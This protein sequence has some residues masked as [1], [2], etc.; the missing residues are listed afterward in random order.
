LVAGL[1][2]SRSV[3][4]SF[5]IYFLCA[6]AGYLW[7]EVAR[8]RS[9]LAAL[10]ASPAGPRSHQVIIT[11]RREFAT[12]G[13]TSYV[14]GI[15]RASRQVLLPLWGAHIG[16]DVTQISLVYGVSSIIDVSL[17]YPSGSL[18][19]RYGRRAV[20]IPCMGFLAVGHLLLPLT[21]SA[22]SLLLVAL[23]LGFGN[24][25]G[26]GIVMTLGADR[27]PEVGRP[28]F[29]ALWRLV[30]DA[31]ASSGPLLDSVLIGAV[32]LSVAGPL[33]GVLGVA[34]TLFT[35]RFLE[36]THVVPERA[37]EVTETVSPPTSESSTPE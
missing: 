15:L 8:D 35:A 19:D 25:L 24:G 7:L 21:H 22:T 3:T 37:R 23:L 14:L 13:V 12:A 5:V 11:H 2:S 27:A 6:S 28:A 10:F 32:S 1:A 36:E 33:V 9:D 34:A 29:L 4:V 17:F 20:A 26:A 31:G 30:S 16:L 18:S